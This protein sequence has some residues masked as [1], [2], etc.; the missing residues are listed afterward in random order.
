MSM[1]SRYRF[2][3]EGVRRFCGLQQ[4][5]DAR[6]LCESNINYMILTKDLFCKLHQWVLNSFFP[7][8]LQIDMAKIVAQGVPPIKQP[9]YVFTV[10]ISACQ[11]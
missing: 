4:L 5:M 11:Q 2:E 6:K 7:P 1:V 9:I 8:F 10:K 3:S